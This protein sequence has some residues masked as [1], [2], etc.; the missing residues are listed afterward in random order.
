MKHLSA[1]IQLILILSLTSIASVVIA[2]PFYVVIASFKEE[3]HAYRF[4][5]SVRD[6]FPEASFRSDPAQMIHHVFVRET[7]IMKEAEEFRSHLHR[8]GFGDAW[9]LADLKSL[10]TVTPRES[11]VKLEL[12]TGSSVLLSSA[13]N[14]FL[15]IAKNKSEISGLTGGDSGKAFKFVAKNASGRPVPATVTLLNDLGDQ[16]SRFKTGEVVAFKGRQTLNFLCRAPGYS[17]VAKLIDLSDI[18]GNTSDV[19]QDG[20][21]V[22][23]LTFPVVRQNVNEINLRYHSLFHTDAAVLHDISKRSLEALVTMLLSN[24]DWRISIKTHCNPGVRRRIFLPESGSPFDLSLATAKDG[25]D[26]KLTGEQAQTLLAYLVGKG[27]DS[28]R[29]SIMAWGGLDRVVEQTE[30]SAFLNDRVEMEL[31]TNYN[32]NHYKF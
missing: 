16:E 13:D 7:S 15:A 28:R 25:S 10:P 32:Y 21:G 29:I 11:V 17:P 2:G 9:I 4:S 23:E 19:A 24:A 26:K 18:G 6:V 27:I 14:S 8:I 30:P 3:T 12:Y 5:E 20:D 1:I 22:W 31:V